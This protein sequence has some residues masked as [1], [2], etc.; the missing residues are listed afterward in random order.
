MP[1]GVLLHFTI[2]VWIFGER[3]FP[4][5]V[6]S[7]GKSGKWDSGEFNVDGQSDV[8]ARLMRVN[9]L[10][11]FVCLI[12]SAALFIVAYS[13][14]GLRIY[15]QRKRGGVNEEMEGCPPVKVAIERMLVMGLTSYHISSNPDYRALFPPGDPVTRGV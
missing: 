12:L 2:A 9:G 7:G 10:V 4:S 8:L 3:D 14:W 15:Q 11:P 5:Y 13:V 6:L 1:A